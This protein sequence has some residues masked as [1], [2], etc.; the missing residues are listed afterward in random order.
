[1]VNNI[2]QGDNIIVQANL[3]KTRREE[4]ESQE[5]GMKM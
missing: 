3:C 2:E 5:G 1:M 4:G